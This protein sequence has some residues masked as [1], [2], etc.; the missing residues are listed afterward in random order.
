MTFKA[1]NIH[2]RDTG[3]YQVANFTT[4]ATRGGWSQWEGGEVISDLRTFVGDIQVPGGQICQICS[5]FE[6]ECYLKSA[7]LPI[8]LL[9]GSGQHISFMQ[10]RIKGFGF[11]VF[12]VSLSWGEQFFR[13]NEFCPN[14]PVQCFPKIA[15]LHIFADSWVDASFFP[16]THD[17]KSIMTFGP[18]MPEAYCAADWLIYQQ[19]ERVRIWG[20]LGVSQLEEGGRLIHQL[21]QTCRFLLVNKMPRVWNLYKL[22]AYLVVYFCDFVFA[23]VFFC[24]V[25]HS[26]D[27]CCSSRGLSMIFSWISHHGPFLTIPRHETG[28]PRQARTTHRRWRSTSRP[29]GLPCTWKADWELTTWNIPILS[30]HVWYILYLHL[31]DFSGKCGWI[32]YNNLIGYRSMLCIYTFCWHIHWYPI[33]A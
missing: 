8:T 7:L 5:F 22:Y 33:F 30:I 28:K 16:L 10:V 15:F 19:I 9:L 29:K 12:V 11:Q 32:P 4:E 18:Q 2:P 6:N 20:A 27:V 14:S 21:S 25:P 31:L 1:P 23:V 26:L 17:V 3:N 13:W 24:K